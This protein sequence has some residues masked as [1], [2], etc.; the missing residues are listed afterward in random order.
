[1]SLL[2]SYRSAVARKQEELSR[3]QQEQGREQGKVADYQRKAGQAREAASR[4][5]T[6][7]TI[8]SK[9]REAERYDKNAAD[10]MKKVADIGRRIAQ[11]QTDINNEQKKVQQAEKQEREKAA[12]EMKRDTDNRNREMQSMTNSLSSLRYRQ[13]KA[14]SEI[15]RLK[16][17]PEK[18]VV[19]FLAANPKGGTHL[20][21]DEEAREIREKI[22]QSEHRDAVQ[23]ETRWAVRS[24]DIL[25]AINELNPT[26][27][28]FSG[29]GV[30]DG[31][32]VLEDS[33][34]EAKVVS[35]RGI[36]ETMQTASDSIRLVVLNA[37]HSMVGAGCRRV[38]G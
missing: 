34:G 28:H 14:E 26:V 20:R 23:L 13:T 1:M 37:C 8:T 9:L 19:L 38:W 30:T 11:K 12:R 3:L 33:K 17:L 29:H 32:L 4:T 24:M 6:M 10:A 18:I 22:R 27:V 36:T 25:Q 15:E 31:N 16:A 7:S 35:I 21:L 5:K 2:D